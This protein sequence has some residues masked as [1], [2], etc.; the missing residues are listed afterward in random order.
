[1]IVG[2]VGARAFEGGTRTMMR[3]EKLTIAKIYVPVKRRATLKPLC[4]RLRKAYLRSGRRPQSR[5][6]AMASASS[7]CTVCIGLRRARHWA[8]SRS[9]R[10]LYKPKSTSTRNQKFEPRGTRC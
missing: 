7:S 3:R 5:S 2:I 6:G 4:E 1:M 8:K 10:T 9:L